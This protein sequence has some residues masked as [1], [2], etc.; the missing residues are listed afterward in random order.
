[1]AEDRRGLEEDEGARKFFFQQN[2]VLAFQAEDRVHVV[3]WGE[4][5]KGRQSQCFSFF[6]CGGSVR[7]CNL[8]VALKE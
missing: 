1:M 6:L 4:P 5:D 3:T 7:V 2:P 8:N